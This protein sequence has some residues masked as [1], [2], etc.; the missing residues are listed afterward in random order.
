LCGQGSHG[1][2][3]VLELFFAAFQI[4]GPLFQIV[5]R[6]P[7]ERNFHRRLVEGLRQNNVGQQFFPPPFEFFHHLPRVGDTPFQRSGFLAQGL[8]VAFQG[9]AT[10]VVGFLPGSEFVGL[11]LE[12]RGLGRMVAAGFTP[13]VREPFLLGFH[14]RPRSAQAFA[15]SSA[16]QVKLRLRCLE[17]RHAGFQTLLGVVELPFTPGEFLFAWVDTLRHRASLR[18]RNNP[19]SLSTRE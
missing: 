16:G 11:G 3:V 19:Q 8:Q 12:G 10:F 13:F 17:L 7:V 15:Q 4:A 18:Y 6:G 5:I 1:R 14:L 9:D 2:S